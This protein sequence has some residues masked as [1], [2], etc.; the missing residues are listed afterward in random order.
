MEDLYPAAEPRAPGRGSAETTLGGH[1]PPGRRFEEDATLSL[2]GQTG[3]WKMVRQADGRGATRW[4]CYHPK[5][6]S[7]REQAGRSAVLPPPG[8]AIGIRQG[9]GSVQVAIVEGI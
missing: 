1:A 2:Q 9:R 3:N 4:G 7:V 6:G 8:T 5:R